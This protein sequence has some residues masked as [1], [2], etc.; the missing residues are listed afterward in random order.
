MG[1]G[2]EERV[3]AVKGPAVKV[4]GRQCPLP[5]GRSEVLLVSVGEEVEDT[6]ELALLV[7]S[8]RAGYCGE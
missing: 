8:S 3:E 1:H 4:A 7:G 6:T 5:E 2:L